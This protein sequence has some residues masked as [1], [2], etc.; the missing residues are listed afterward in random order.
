MTELKVI[1][2]KLHK[3]VY[4]KSIRKNGKTI[5]PKKSKVFTFWVPVD[6]AA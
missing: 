4:C 6:D 3:K 1:N 5:Y 2:G